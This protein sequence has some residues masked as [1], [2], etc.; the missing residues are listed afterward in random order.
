MQL[1]SYLILTTASLSL[2][3]TNSKKKKILRLVS[4]NKIVMLNK[5]LALSPSFGA[6]IKLPPVHA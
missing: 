6:L 4:S 2:P 3:V 5:V 1:F